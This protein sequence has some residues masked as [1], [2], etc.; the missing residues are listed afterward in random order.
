M[1]LDHFFVALALFCSNL[2]FFIALDLVYL[3]IGHFK[4]NQVEVFCHLQGSLYCVKMWSGSHY[5]DLKFVA[6][7]FEFLAKISPFYS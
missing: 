7:R 5:S 4:S 6:N 3:A 1:A 2:L